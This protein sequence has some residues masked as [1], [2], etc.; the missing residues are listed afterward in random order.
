MIDRKYAYLIDFD[1]VINSYTSGWDED[2][3]GAT[4]LPD[5]PVPGVK[6]ALE[7]LSQ[8]FRIVIF[9]TRAKTSEG[10]KAVCDWLTK[11]DIYHDKV[12]NKKEAGLLLIDDRA[13][14]F[15]G[16]WTQTLEDIR[17]FKHWMKK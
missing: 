12:T 13:I 4:W 2:K 3:G 17:S 5:P 16:D 11:Y 1:G 6:E 8:R 7:E 15:K 10:A 9:T 14:T